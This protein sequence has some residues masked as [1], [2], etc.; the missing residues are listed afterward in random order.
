MGK[1]L[2][3]A[4]RKALAKRDDTEQ[5]AWEAHGR[6][7]GQHPATRGGARVRRFLRR[8]TNKARRR[9]TDPMELEEDFCNWR[10][11]HF[12]GPHIVGV[13]TL[14]RMSCT[15]D[16]LGIDP[17]QPCPNCHRPTKVIK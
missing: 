17:E 1:P 6:R 15:E 13:A 3:R 14:Y 16:L 2:S 10:P 12:E 5:N 8:L 11:E 7:P 4:E 9:G